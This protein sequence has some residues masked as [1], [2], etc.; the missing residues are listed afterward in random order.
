MLRE[1][2]YKQ[3]TNAFKIHQVVAILGPRQCGK[4]TVSKNYITDT[5]PDFN[6]NNYF[7]LESFT[8]LARL[9]NPEIVLGELSGLIVIDEIQKIPN[10][11]QIIRVLVDSDKNKKFLILGSASRELIRQSSESLAGRIQYIELTPFRYSETHELKKLW[12]R[13][14]FPRSYLAESDELSNIWRKSYTQTF[15]EQDIP[16]LGIQ[17]SPMNLRRFWLM[18]AHYHGNICNYSELGR[19]L[20]LNHKTMKHYSDILHATFMIRQLN[21]WYENLGKRLVK[22]HKIYFR[23]S[24]IF[25]SLIG[26]DNYSSLTINPKLGASWE[27]FA[28]EEIIRHHQARDNE[29]F[30]FAIQAGAE[31]DLLILKDGRKIG[32]E[33]KYTDSPKLTKSLK[34]ATELLKLEEIYLIY[35]G[36]KTFRLSNEVKAYPLVDYLNQDIS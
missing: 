5:I 33:F 3:I 28:L 24:G 13:G 9:Q 21:P 32:F 8:D 1:N 30:F 36:D 26:I 15:L 16:N 11:F 31:L 20:D 23:D 22:S 12:V 6:K 4:T 34:I 19:S 29:C 35:P 7:D 25:H 14:G 27:G 18:L 17:I 10:L 2:Y